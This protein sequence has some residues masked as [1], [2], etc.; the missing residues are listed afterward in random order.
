M[1]GSPFTRAQ[2]CAGVF[3]G[4]DGNMLAANICYVLTIFAWAGALSFI[5][6]YLLDAS[7]GLRVKEVKRPGA[8]AVT[9][10]REMMMLA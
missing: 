7:I 10:E 2:H 3:Y 6:I 8:K 9:K 5:M 1:N 4:G